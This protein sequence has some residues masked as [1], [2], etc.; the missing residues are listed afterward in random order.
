MG[1]TSCKKQIKNENE[2]ESEKKEHH[3]VRAINAGC[4]DI[5]QGEFNCKCPQQE[6][7]PSKPSSEHWPENLI[8]KCT[9]M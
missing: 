1:H 9:H 7:A 2:P 4:T 5:K 3:P 6:S 8:I